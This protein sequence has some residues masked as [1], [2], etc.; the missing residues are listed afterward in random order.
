MRD[1]A[2]SGKLKV[3]VEKYKASDKGQK[4]IKDYRRSDRN[5]EL[6]RE[7]CQSPKGALCRVNRLAKYRAHKTNALPSWADEKEIR[8]IYKNCPAGLEVDHI[9]PLQG[10][11]ISGLHV[12][13]NM[14]YLTRSENARKSNSFDGTYDNNGWRNE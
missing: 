8:L 4:K 13:W 3:S 1:Y 2:K 7:Y 14:Q 6:Q 9:I 10:E 5:K 11:L 12:P